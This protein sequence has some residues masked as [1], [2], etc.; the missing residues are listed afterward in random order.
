[1][2]VFSYQASDY[3]AKAIRGTVAA[4]TPR[5]AREKLRAQGLV[6]EQI[7]HLGDSSQSSK[8]SLIGKNGLLTRIL[9]RPGRRAAQLG[10]AIRDLATLIGTGI[11]LVESLDTLTNQFT[12]RFQVALM[13]LRERVAA[14]SGLAEAMRSDTGIFD[15]LTIQ[16]VEVGE[17]SGT[18]DVVLDQ[19]ADFRERY[20]TF[21]DR[22]TTALLYP[23]IVV[24]L[25]IGVSVFLM[26]V[27]LPMLLEH[28]VESGQKLPWPTQV[29]KTLSDIATTHGLWIFGVFVVLAMLVVSFAR[30]PRGKRLFHRT[31]FK[32][33]ILGPLA[34]KQ[35]IARIALII[36]T[37]MKSGVVFVESARIA[38]RATKN[39]L[40]REALDKMR[41]C[42]QSGQDIGD[43]LQS[44]EIFPP[45]VIQIFTVGQ[46]TGKL[47][48][49]LDRLSSS[50]ERQVE[51]TT[52]RLTAALE[53]ILIVGLAIMVG[54][55]LFATILP[56][57][58]A[59]NVL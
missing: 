16:M 46:Q 35:E 1:M 56:I 51:S 42:V 10:T 47:E 8:T 38:G 57:L 4:D 12:G 37:L 36:S 2:A 58:E 50:Y 24:G 54:F 29:L 40:L 13:A 28:L 34:K 15:E 32:L 3:S 26:T 49:M 7:S 30:R 45:L 21:K 53:P 33:P 31:I 59:G 5:E 48:A 19:L 55:I 9:D 27:V 41:E 6:I 44:T 23:V 25:A 52:S 18:L 43:A 17:N 11:G 20:L 14:G 39:I 22:V